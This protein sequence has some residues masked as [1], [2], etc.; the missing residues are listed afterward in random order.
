MSFCHGVTNRYPK[1]HVFRVTR[2]RR[3]VWRTYGA[4]KTSYPSGGS[5]GL[6]NGTPPNNVREVIKEVIVLRSVVT[7]CRHQ[8]LCPAHRCTG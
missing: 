2:V 1:R 7:K 3:M 8:L 6:M 5:A 4:E